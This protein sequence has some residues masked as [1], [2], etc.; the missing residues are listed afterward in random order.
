MAYV[1]EAH[2]LLCS[3]CYVI[4]LYAWVLRR[5]MTRGNKKHLTSIE[6]TN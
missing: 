1:F 2:I 4:Q 6:V 3:L 5:N